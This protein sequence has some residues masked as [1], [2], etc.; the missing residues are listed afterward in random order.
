V[1]RQRISDYLPHAVELLARLGLLVVLHKSGRPSRSLAAI[2]EFQRIDPGAHRSE[3]F[4]IQNACNAEP[5]PRPPLLH[6]NNSKTSI[7]SV[8]FNYGTESQGASQ[9]GGRETVQTQALA[10]HRCGG[11]SGLGGDACRR[12]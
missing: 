12:V 6:Y 9:G 2:L 4:R 5:H 10:R 7:L 8:C 3:L 11:A 1:T